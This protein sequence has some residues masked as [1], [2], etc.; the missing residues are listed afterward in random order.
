MPFSKLVYEEI[1]AY[2]LRKTDS[3]VPHS[4]FLCDAETKHE[5]TFY[6]SFLKKKKVIGDAQLVWLSG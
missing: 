2:Y 1:T 4:I 6:M 3:F 5:L